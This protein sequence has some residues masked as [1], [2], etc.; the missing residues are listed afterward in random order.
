MLQRKTNQRGYLKK[1]LEPRCLGR[2]DIIANNNPTLETQEIAMQLSRPYKQ[3][4]LERRIMKQGIRYRNPLSDPSLS[5]GSDQRSA[6]ERLQH[7]ASK[8]VS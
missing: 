2:E 6:I 3:E 8:W 1:G 7:G 5:F 4:V